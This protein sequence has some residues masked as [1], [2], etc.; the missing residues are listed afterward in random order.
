[1][2]GDGKYGREIW[3]EIWTGKYGDRRDVHLIS[4]G[5]LRFLISVA[6]ALSFAYFAKD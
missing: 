1:M 4:G 6:R 5:W 3:G 2:C